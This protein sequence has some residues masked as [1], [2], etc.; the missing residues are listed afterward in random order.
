MGDEDA[1]A[2]AAAE[3]AAHLEPALRVLGSLQTEADPERRYDL[4]LAL[5]H[6]TSERPDLAAKIRTLVAQVL[7]IDVPKCGARL[8]LNP[9]KNHIVFI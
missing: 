1:E 5:G 6:I 9:W 4:L 3:E 8:A 2:E 7:G